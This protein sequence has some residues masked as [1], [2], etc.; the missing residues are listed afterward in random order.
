MPRTGHLR[1]EGQVIRHSA[2]LI[3]GFKSQT[4]SVAAQVDA[5]CHPLISLV[6]RAAALRS[7][8]KLLVP[9]VRRS[10]W[11]PSGSP[12]HENDVSLK[13]A[14]FSRNSATPGPFSRF[15]RT[16]PFQFHPDIRPLWHSLRRV[17]SVTD[18]WNRTFECLWYA[19]KS[20]A[21]QWASDAV[22]LLFDSQER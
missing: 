17:F 4:A 2:T 10:I 13:P 15:E 7:S 20:Q 6:F 22:P 14:F 11:M 21:F 5:G 19:C 12:T 9:F 18:L 1:Q 16:W 8:T 3:T